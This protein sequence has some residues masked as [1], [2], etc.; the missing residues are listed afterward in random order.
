MTVARM[1]IRPSF[2]HPTNLQDDPT[3]PDYNVPERVDAFVAAALMWANY[4]R[5]PDVIFMMGEMRDSF[6]RSSG[7]VICLDSRGE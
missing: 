3:S 5:T 2:V 6:F 4:S 1:M 7:A